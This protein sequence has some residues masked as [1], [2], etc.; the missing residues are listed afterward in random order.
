M[1]SK[2]EK[3]TLKYL[4]RPSNPHYDFCFN[5][6][7]ILGTGAYGRV[8]KGQDRHGNPVAIKKIDFRKRWCDKDYKT[9]GYSFEAIKTETNIIKYLKDDNIIKFL[10]SYQS[11]TG[12]YIVQ[13]F[14]NGGNLHDFLQNRKKVKE[15]SAIK[16]ITQIVGGLGYLVKNGIAHRDL[17]PMNILIVEGRLKLADFGLSRF[18]GIS[19][20]MISKV[21]TSLYMPPQI[22]SH[23]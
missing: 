6:T 22:L 8:Y 9:D 11:K 13:E 16:Y 17:K 15:E 4:K 5:P 2:T 21:G 12:V 3:P 19:Q 10:D 14:A 20:K 23:N 1:A 7:D 18:I